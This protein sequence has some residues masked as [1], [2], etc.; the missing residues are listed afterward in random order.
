MFDELT[1]GMAWFSERDGP[2]G[3][4]CLIV[5]MRKLALADL[6]SSEPLSH[7]GSGEIE[8]RRATWGED[9]DG[10]VRIAWRGSWTL[11]LRGGASID[12]VRAF[13]KRLK[14]A[15][16]QEWQAA[17]GQSGCMPMAETCGG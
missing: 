8:G 10:I 1:P 17:G 14:S 4:G 11:E 6:N 13:A 16:K 9:A 15:T 5:T 7:A 12:E 3:S 2:G